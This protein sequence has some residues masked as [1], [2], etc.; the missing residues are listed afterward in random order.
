MPGTFNYACWMGMIYGKIKVVDSIGGKVLTEAE[1]AD[2]GSP[3]VADIDAE[4]YQVAEVKD[5]LQELMVTI[6]EMGFS[7]TLLVV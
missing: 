7:P 3:D 5:G 2:S 6:D 4:N 1:E